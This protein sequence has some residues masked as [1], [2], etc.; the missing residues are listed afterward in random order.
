[1]RPAALLIVAG[2]LAGGTACGSS[3]HRGARVA[4][5][6]SAASHGSVWEWTPSCRFGPRA[7]N[8][9]T[10]APPLIG[11]A[12]LAGNAWNLGGTSATT[13]SVGMSV[14][15]SGA[16]E[17][18]A[19]VSSAAPC[20]DPTCIT[21]EANTWVRGYPSVLYGIDQCHAATS[22]PQSSDLRLPA[23]VQAFRSGLVGAATYATKASKVTYDV[24]YDM[25][26]NP[27]DTKTP[28]QADGTVE[29]M[30]WTDYDAQSLLPDTLKVG[31]ATIPFA[32]NGHDDPGTDAWSVYVNN[33]FERGRTVPWGGTV[34]L[35]LDAARKVGNGS[36]TVD[37]GAALEQAGAMLENKYGW[38]RFADNY[39]LDTIAFGIEV[40]PANA[41]PYG[42]GPL[43]FSLRLSSYCLAVRT[44]VSAAV[45]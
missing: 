33:V 30:V 7:Q 45:C 38:R 44:R 2:L 6:P 23:K 16:V 20:S 34:W 9:C 40:G 32:S 43:D 3:D 17:M 29:V 14:A 26:L 11:A 13:G 24:A 1:M 35:V 15:A 21:R 18:K 25:W 22:P 31:S 37:L 28:C 19:D 5:V 8:G 39:W 27:S 10:A 41:D 12:Q 36:V 4:L 42:A